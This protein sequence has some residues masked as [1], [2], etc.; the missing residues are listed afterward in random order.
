MDFSSY[1]SVSELDGLAFKVTDLNG[2]TTQYVLSTDTSQYY[3][4]TD[5]NTSP[6]TVGPSY[7]PESNFPTAP[8]NLKDSTTASYKI[9]N[10][11]NISGCSS[12]ADVAV[13]IKAQNIGAFSNVSVSADKI[14]C[15]LS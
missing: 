5:V 7:Y 12:W 8:I 11:I 15:T 2:Y 6:R 3:A 4:R 10:V 13:R 14:F 1:N 9:A